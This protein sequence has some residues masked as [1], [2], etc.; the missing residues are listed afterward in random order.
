MHKASSHGAAGTGYINPQHVIL[1]PGEGG[2]GSSFA[3]DIIF[4]MIIKLTVLL[5]FKFP[6]LSKIYEHF[7]IEIHKFS[8]KETFDLYFVLIIYFITV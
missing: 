2:P 8:K 1:E 7:R 5:F 6:K 3:L 4:Q